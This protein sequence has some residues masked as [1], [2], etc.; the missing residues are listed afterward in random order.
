M[1]AFTFDDFDALLT[2]VSTSV[3]DVVGRPPSGFPSVASGPSSSSGRASTATG[4]TPPSG[5]STPYMLLGSVLVAG[6]AGSSTGSGKK[7][8]SI[9]IAPN[10]EEYC[11]GLINNSKFCT[12]KPSTCIVAAHGS[13]KF[14][15][16]DS[17]SYLRDTEIRAWCQPEIDVSKLN[18]AQL[19]RLRE[20]QLT[21]TEW[22]ELSAQMKQGDVPKWLAFGATKEQNPN[23]EIDTK[24]EA[25]LDLM[26]P[27]AQEQSGSLL[28]L[29][30]TLSYDD[31][32]DSSESGFSPEDLELRDIAT[33]VGK[34]RANF[35][36]L[37]QKWMR[38]FVE[39][40]AGYGLVVK[41]LQ[42]L[43]QA[44][45]M[46]QQNI[47]S[48]PI[49]DD[50]A[51][52]GSRPM[53]DDKATL[54]SSFTALQG[55][56]LSAT[57]SLTGHAT[58]IGELSHQQTSLT[59]MVTALEDT[60]D[61]VSSS[62]D[63]E[64][65][66]LEK[67]LRAIEQRMLKLLPLLNHLKGSRGSGNTLPPDQS[68]QLKDRLDEYAQRL[69][70]LQELVY[71]QALA[72]TST[73]RGSSAIS[74]TP[75]NL[76]PSVTPPSTDLSEVLSQL[77]TVQ[78]EM[79]QLQL[80]VVGKGVQIANKTFQSFDDV[81]TWVTTHLPNCRYGLFMDGVSIFEFFTHGHID[82]ETTY[83]SFYSQHRTGFQSSYEARVAS[84][85][86]N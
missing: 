21:V 51:T 32:V 12:R 43:G 65:H 31:S 68:T 9:L 13:K 76:P 58:Q 26:S 59:Q 34:F 3:P 27:F 82:A 42:K 39:V 17:T 77:R 48:H 61:Y 69:Q 15:P 74:V 64:V 40:E 38:A 8:V 54:W 45:I 29:I 16:A 50:K 53:S 23:L 18:R 86:Q 44:T 41:D 70:V 60:T 1:S 85:I 72:S 47:G 5:E 20:T 66:H 49:S 28:N 81:K 30:P 6:G 11:M 4:G 62:L 55:T 36:H 46:C 10:A 80:R 79:K 7:R 75:V 73:P 37:K 33:Y 2:S 25:G 84:S 52:I 22:T 57:T 24:V 35:H 67:D 78:T 71:D 19:N 63:T 14:H 83:S 56:V